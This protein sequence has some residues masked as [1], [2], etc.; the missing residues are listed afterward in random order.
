MF[1]HLQDQLNKI[2]AELTFFQ[3]RNKEDSYQNQSHYQTE[4]REQANT[5]SGLNSE[6]S[7][8][9][10]DKERLK[11]EKN[12]IKKK[13]DGLTKHFHDDKRKDIQSHD[14]EYLNFHDETVAKLRKDLE[15][16]NELKIKEYKLVLFYTI[17]VLKCRLLVGKYFLTNVTLFH[18]YFNFL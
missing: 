3:E 6:L 2:T 11:K 4:L 16:E 14:K 10:L 15:E 12:E 13:L 18:E 9:R 7:Q 17:L 5:I 8:L 1:G